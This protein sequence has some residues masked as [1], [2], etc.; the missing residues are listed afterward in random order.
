[1][2]K[3]TKFLVSMF[4]PLFLYALVAAAFDI[5]VDAFF[6]PTN[7]SARLFVVLI[8]VSLVYLILVPWLRFF[9]GES[10]GQYL[11]P[12]PRHWS[13]DFARAQVFLL[14]LLLLSE[15]IFLA[16]NWAGIAFIWQDDWARWAFWLIPLLVAI[17]LQTSAEEFMMRGFYQDKLK[18]L[19]VSR[20]VYIGAPAFVWGFVHQSM[21][22]TIDLKIAMVLQMLIIGLILGDWVERAGHLRGVIFVHFLLNAFTML[23]YV[24]SL[25]PTS[26]YILKVDVSHLSGPALWSY[27]ALVSIGATISY[28]FLVR[29]K[30]GGAHDIQ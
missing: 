1:M 13:K 2:T 23:I 30:L 15:P 14:G 12:K 20:R 21:F 28:V 9:Y 25:R 8:R 27:F 10:L 16:L 5:V 19:G 26:N 3:T 29:P 18:G 11:G 24:S 6:P 22:G 17:F 4:V 7:S